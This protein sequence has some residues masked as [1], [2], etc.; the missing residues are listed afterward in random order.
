MP[1]KRDA[2]RWFL[3]STATLSVLLCVAFGCKTH[4]GDGKATYPPDPTV[5]YSETEEHKRQM[6]EQA[7]RLME[8]V[9]RDEQ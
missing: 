5:E 1:S 8:G 9:K 4:L 2:R 7:E 6:E 3:F